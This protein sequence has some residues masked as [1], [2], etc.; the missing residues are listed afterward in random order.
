MKLTNRTQAWIAKLEKTMLQKD[1]LRLVEGEAVEVG[2]RSCCG[3]THQTMK[4]FEMF[5]KLLKALKSQG[6]DVQETPVIHKNSYA[7][8][9]GGFWNSFIF[10]VVK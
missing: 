1:A 8:S 10:E 7:T 5:R 6:V 9:N 4:E 2:Y 3:V